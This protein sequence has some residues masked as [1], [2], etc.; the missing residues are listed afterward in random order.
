MNGL[1]SSHPPTPCTFPPSHLLVL[2]DFIPTRFMLFFLLK[3]KLF[4]FLLASRSTTNHFLGASAM[5]LLGSLYNVRPVMAFRFL[6]LPYGYSINSQWPRQVC[7]TNEICKWA[8]GRPFW[9]ELCVV[10][11]TTGHGN[12][13]D[14]GNKSVCVC[15]CL[16]V[17]LMAAQV[18]S[19][20]LSRSK[21]VKGRAEE[22][23]KKENETRK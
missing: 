23:K 11:Q 2:F 17:W 19:F 3:Q 13:V 16:C 12:S 5:T 10:K 7:R 8:T 15:V 21:R 1:L 6:L 14:R 20:W 18:P 9:A 22:E 4:F